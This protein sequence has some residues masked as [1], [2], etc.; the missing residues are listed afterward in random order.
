MEWVGLR[1]YDPHGQLGDRSLLL[2]QQRLW[3]RHQESRGGP[4][5]RGPH[6]QGGVKVRGWL[7]LA[8][9][10]KKRAQIELDEAEQAR[11]SVAGPSAVGQSGED[12]KA[13]ALKLLAD[14]ERQ[15][16]ALRTEG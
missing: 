3:K 6:A 16:N 4:T 8:E 15:I 14:A 12:A 1:P 2:L 5:S 10:A 11:G 9:A 13:N 7:L